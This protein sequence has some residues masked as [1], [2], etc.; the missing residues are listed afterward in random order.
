MMFAA[1]P[2][3]EA[4]LPVTIV[5]GFLGSGKTTLLN[6][7]LHENRTRK[8][9]VLVNEFGDINIDSQLLVEFKEDMVELTNGCICC[10]LNDGLQATVWKILARRESIDYLL[11]ETTGIADPLPIILTFTGS[12]LWSFTRLDSIVTLVDATA[13]TADHFD[14]QAAYRQMTYGDILLLNKTDLVSEEQI[15]SLEA[16]I[17]KLKPGARILCSRYGQIPLELLLDVQMTDL[18]SFTEVEYSA[19]HRVDD[20]FDTLSFQSD[21][22]FSLRK[23]QQFLDYQLSAQVFRAKGILWFT[24]SPD[25]HLFQ[26]SGKRYTLEDSFWH[27]QPANQLVCIGRHFNKLELLQ[28]LNNCLA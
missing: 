4:K 5:T 26:L 24:E 12:E 9:A 22:P 8:I 20:G 19:N 3:P 2:T 28:Q 14:S 6:H 10:T 17:Q 11:V 16:T 13:F 18:N 27:E 15:R 1:P 21:R 7:I 23:F 25:R